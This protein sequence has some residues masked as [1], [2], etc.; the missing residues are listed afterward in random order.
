MIEE[1]KNA[2]NTDE[3]VDVRDFPEV[4]EQFMERIMRVGSDDIDVFH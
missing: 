2:G 1:R 3:E 4:I